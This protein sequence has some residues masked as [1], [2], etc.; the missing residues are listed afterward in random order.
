MCDE[1][2]APMVSEMLLLLRNKEKNGAKRKTNSLTV[3]YNR[4]TKP[5]EYLSIHIEEVFADVKKG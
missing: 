5:E 3:I 1:V 4:S 2:D